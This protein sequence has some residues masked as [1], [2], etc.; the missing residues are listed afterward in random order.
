DNV[1]INM[2]ADAVKSVR[3]VD[4]GSACETT[5]LMDV[6]R[7]AEFVREAKQLGTHGY[8]AP[9]ILRNNAVNSAKTDIYSF[10]VILAELMSEYNFQALVIKAL[11]ERGPGAEITHEDVVAMMPDIFK[12]G[13]RP[14]PASLDLKDDRIEH[15]KYQSEKL[16]VQCWNK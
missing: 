9:E 7:Q 10:G 1:I 6:A 13:E 14:L 2:V 15:I 12:N 16:Q 3:I 11:A 5:D 8:Y 4:L